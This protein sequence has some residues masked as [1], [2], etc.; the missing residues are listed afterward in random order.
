MIIIINDNLPKICEE[1]KGNWRQT[2]AY[3]TFY[4]QKLK[5]DYIFNTKQVYKA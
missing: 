4:F 2:Y 3:Q 1:E 5:L